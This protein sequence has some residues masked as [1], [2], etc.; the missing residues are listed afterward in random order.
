[1]LFVNRMLPACE[2]LLEIVV[3]GKLRSVICLNRHRRFS[4]F[5]GLWKLVRSSG[6]HVA[7]FFWSQKGHF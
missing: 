5:I 7:W 6:N 4:F 2:K 1:M 3:T